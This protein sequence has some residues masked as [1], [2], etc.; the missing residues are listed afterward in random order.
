MFLPLQSQ[1]FAFL[2]KEIYLSFRHLGIFALC[3]SPASSEQRSYCYLTGF[4]IYQSFVIILR[5]CSCTP[6]MFYLSNI[7]PR[8][9]ARSLGFQLLINYI[10][11]RSLL[12]ILLTYRVLAVS[13]R[14][15]N[16]AAHVQTYKYIHLY[17]HTY[18]YTRSVWCECGCLHTHVYLCIC[19]CARA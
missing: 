5:D 8:H 2:H 18:T 3:N 12:I 19:M 11:Q 13:V 1:P 16:E 14:K 9:T 10:K 4:H 17:M 15:Y 7:A 6:I